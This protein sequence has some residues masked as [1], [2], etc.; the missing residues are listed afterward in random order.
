MRIALT[1]RVSRDYRFLTAEFM[2]L[3]ETKKQDR[4]RLIISDLPLSCKTRLAIAG[5]NPSKIMLQMFQL[6]TV[7]YRY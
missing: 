5:W 4:Q 2:L 6:K 7:G 1:K 3:Y